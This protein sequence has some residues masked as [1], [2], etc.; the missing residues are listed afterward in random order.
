MHLSP[1]IWG[2]AFVWSTLL[3][4]SVQANVTR[5][6]QALGVSSTPS[7]K[8][9]RPAGCCSPRGAK[10]VRPFGLGAPCR[11]SSQCLPRSACIQGHCQRCNTSDT[12]GNGPCAVWRRRKHTSF[13]VFRTAMIISASIVAALLGCFIAGVITRAFMSQPDHEESIAFAS[14][15]STAMAEPEPRVRQ[16]RPP[17]YTDI[18]REQQEELPSYV[19]AMRRP[20]TSTPRTNPAYVIDIT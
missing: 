10:H 20:M 19:E 15:S 11:W 17:T 1:E 7:T 5:S 8:T 4:V 2:F 13:H 18:L 16:E 12:V 14:S 3:A 9:P 6:D